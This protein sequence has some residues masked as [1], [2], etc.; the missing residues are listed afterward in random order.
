MVN[1]SLKK[2]KNHLAGFDMVL[3]ERTT[4]IA[5][6]KG[7]QGFQHTKACFRD[8]IIP[9]V[10]ALKDIFN[11]FIQYLIDEL[12]KVQNVFNQMEQAVEQRRLESKTFEDK[13]NQ[14]LN[15]NNRLLEQVINKDIVNIVVNS[16]VDNASVNVHESQSQEKDMVIRKLKERIKCLTGNVNE[17]KV[18]KDIDEIEMINIELDHMLSKLIAKNE[19][20]KWTYKQLYDLIKPTRVRSKEQC[21]A[22]I[23]QVNQKSVEISELNANLQEQGLIIAAV[24]DELKKLKGKDLVDNAIITHIIAPEM[25]KVNVEPIAPKLLNN[26]IVHSNYLRHTQEQAAILREPSGNTEKDKIQRP[27]SSTQINKIEAHP[28]TVKS[29]LKNKNCDVQPKGTAIVQHFKLKANFELIYVNCNGC[30]LSDNHDLCVLNVINDVNAHAKS[31]SV[32][33]TSKRKV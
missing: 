1:T 29:S 25:L 11:K 15:K 20:L 27:P 3:K 13:M 12:T 19:H 8:E 28:R 9:F 2:L 31:K 21:D 23:N 10:K 33:K 22:L 4:A 14:V 26:G 6:T 24:K 32:K 7:M 16:S 18:K 5:I 17:D 30:M